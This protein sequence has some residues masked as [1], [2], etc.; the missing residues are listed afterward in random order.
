MIKAKSDYVII[1]AERP[2][3]SGIITLKT[4]EYDEKQSFLKGKM[5]IVS[6]GDEVKNLKDGDRVILGS[7]KVMRYDN[8]ASL[9]GER[10]SDNV[11]YFIAHESDIAAVLE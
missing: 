2:S 9:I 4:G 3:T 11:E 5:T 8:F 1:K 10:E 6:A 7:N